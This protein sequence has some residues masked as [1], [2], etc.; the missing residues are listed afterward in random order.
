LNFTCGSLSHDGDPP[1]LDR[2]EYPNVSIPQ[3]SLLG[4]AL[5]TV[6]LLSVTIGFHRWHQ[7]LTGRASINAFAPDAPTGPDWYRR[8]TRAHLNCVENL[9]VYGAIVGTLSVSGIQ[10]AAV[11]VLAA[12]VLGARICQTVTH[13][14][15]V[16]TERA[17]S[18]RFTFYMVQ[19]LAKVGIAI[20]VLHEI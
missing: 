1:S 5:W 12:T 7:I 17:V 18:I 10:A 9:P 13:V 3:L 8:A 2:Q 6:V 14:A 11:D 19:I 15:F 20:F 4:F 16:Q